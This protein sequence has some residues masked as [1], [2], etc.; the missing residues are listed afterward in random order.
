MRVYL[1]SP[2]SQMHAHA[3]RDMPVLISYACTSDWLDDYAPS[4]G[5]VLIDSGAFSEMNTGRKID[6][7]AYA[8]WAEERRGWVEAVA[9]LDD[10]RGDWQRGLKNWRAH[11]WMFPTYHNSDPP[12][13]LETILSYQPKW[14]GLGMVPPRDKR[15]WL[16]ETLERLPAGLHVHGWALQGYADHPRLDSVDSTNWFRDAWQ[17]KKDLPWLTPAECVEIVVK[18]YQRVPRMKRE[19]EPQRQGELAL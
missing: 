7:N 10:I 8:E 4:F 14:L 17:V 13:A 1:S 2:G 9:A 5:S 3:V 11:P 12:E 19:R 15:E 6:L 18:R 16:Y